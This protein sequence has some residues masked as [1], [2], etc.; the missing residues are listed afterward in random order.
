MRRR[1]D[2]A[3]QSGSAGL[4]ALTGGQSSNGSEL[5]VVVAPKTF[6]KEAP[7]RSLLPKT[8]SRVNEVQQI[9]QNVAQLVRLRPWFAKKLKQDIARRC[10]AARLSCHASRE[11]SKLPSWRPR[12]AKTFRCQPGKQG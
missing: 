8:R 3:G 11:R 9:E 10:R 7:E 4:H 6:V 12:P 5:T 2:E 1:S